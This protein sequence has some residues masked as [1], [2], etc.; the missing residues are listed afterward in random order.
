[1]TYQELADRCRHMNLGYRDGTPGTVDDIV[2]RISDLERFL[3][4]SDHSIRYLLNKI[5]KLNE[6]TK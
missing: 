4:Q 6:G 1:M 3:R 5:E 2:Q